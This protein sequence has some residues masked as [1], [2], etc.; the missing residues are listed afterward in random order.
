MARFAA[1][2]QRPAPLLAFVPLLG[3]AVFFGD[4]ATAAVALISAVVFGV[5]RFQKPVG[6]LVAI[7]AGGLLI[8]LVAFVLFVLF[9]SESAR[10]GQP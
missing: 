5:S 10:R 9:V 8:A 6:K 1:R 2:S 7:S 3:N 4:V